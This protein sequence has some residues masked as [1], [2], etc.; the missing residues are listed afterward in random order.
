MTTM[1]QIHFRSPFN[2]KQFFLPSQM[3]APLSYSGCIRQVGEKLIARKIMKK[4]RILLSELKKEECQL[5]K[6][7]NKGRINFCILRWFP[8]HCFPCCLSQ[9]IEANERVTAT[10]LITV[11]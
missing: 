9:D 10:D 7:P 3:P 5:D 6:N 11:V 8:F 4:K 1:L 2:L